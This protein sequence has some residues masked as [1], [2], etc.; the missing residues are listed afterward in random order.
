MYINRQQTIIIKKERITFTLKNNAMEVFKIIVILLTIIGLLFVI[1]QI[2]IKINGI[3]KG[4][5]EIYEHERLERER[6]NIE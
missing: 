4:N 3:R 6:K 5:A 1:S 2:L